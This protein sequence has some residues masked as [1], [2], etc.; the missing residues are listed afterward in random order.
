MENYAGV[1]AVQYPLHT[2]DS[3]PVI[4]PDVGNQH[5]SSL[6]R[7]RIILKS[8]IKLRK[9]YE[10]VSEMV[11]WTHIKSCLNTN[12]HR[13][14]GLLCFVWT[15]MCMPGCTPVRSLRVHSRV[16]GLTRASGSHRY[17]A[18][19]CNGAVLNIVTH[20]CTCVS[21]TRGGTQWS[22]RYRV[23]W[24]R[25]MCGFKHVCSH[26]APCGRSIF[27]ISIRWHFDRWMAFIAAGYCTVGNYTNSTR[28]HP[29]S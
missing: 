5:K 18:R 6:F 15:R 14:C 11:L 21:V 20:D 28:V 27:V 12:V 8:K 13:H 26:P 2:G 10:N 19:N 9:T 22:A 3:V 29:I 4:Q 25:R 7:S 24:H 16:H 1:S 23:G 17:M